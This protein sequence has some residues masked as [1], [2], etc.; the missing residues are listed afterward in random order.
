MGEGKRPN[1]GDL[2]KLIRL[3]AAYPS[4]PPSNPDQRTRMSE[5]KMCYS[6]SLEITVAD[7]VQNLY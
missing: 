6:L 1:F 3:P 7:L 5:C 2:L 4:N